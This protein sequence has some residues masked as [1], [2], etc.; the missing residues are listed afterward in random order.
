MTLLLKKSLV[1]ERAG[2]YIGALTILERDPALMQS[3]ELTVVIPTYNERDNIAPLIERLKHA[4]KG[5]AWQATFVDDNSADGTAETVK[6]MAACDPRILCL[7]RVGRRGLAGA[8]LEG[9]LAS[10]APFIAVIDADLQHDETVLPQML[11][12]LKSGET[13]LAIGSRFLT[14][15]GLEKGLTPF[16]KVGSRLANILARSVLKV[17]VS[18]P[19]SGF[20]MI[21]RDLIEAVAPDLTNDGFKILFDIIASQHSPP[22]IR[23]FPYIFAERQA[24][25]SKMD[26]RV[27]I[28]YLGLI[29]TKLTGNLLPTRFLM[30]AVV[31]LGGVAVHM[32]VLYSGRAAGLQFI[33]SQGVAAM[34]AMT[35][36]FLVNNSVT[37]R[38]RRLRGMR[39]LTGYLRFCALCGVGLLANVAVANLVHEHTPIWW[40]A[41]VAGAASGAAW[42]YVSTSVAVW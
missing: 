2:R 24:G 33:V 38:D 12:S 35:T 3:C 32:A 9:A 4:L 11:A 22:R 39:L 37:Y 40:L 30:F 16:R 34:T 42:N 10:A 13:D 41:G 28:E 21:R 27:I 31:G 20:F 1:D 25:Q 17:E 19:V 5:I 18:D 6:A 26:E 7:K 14:S 29:L 15:S 8:V 23:E 36:N